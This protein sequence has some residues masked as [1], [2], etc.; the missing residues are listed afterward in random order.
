MRQQGRYRK[1]V[2]PVDLSGWSLRA[3]KTGDIARSNNSEV[4]LLHVFRPPASEYA[5]QIALAGQEDQIQQMREE[6]K[7]RLIGIRNE[8]REE[9]IT[10]RVQMIEGM[11]V[12]NVICDYINNEGVDLVSDE[13][14]RHRAG[15]SC[16]AASPTRSSRASTRRCC[17][18]ADKE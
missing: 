12:A 9:N 4:I 7:Q 14:T 11:G 17:S 1:I 2:V 10:V 13:H 8:L 15:A 16:S 5:D 3:S 18:S 6:V